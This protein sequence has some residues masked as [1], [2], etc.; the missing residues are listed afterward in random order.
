MNLK[1][2]VV[3]V[4]GAGKG[5][6]YSTVETL[7]KHGA[8]VYALIKSKKDSK[9]FK[10]F[11][12]K[13]IKIYFGD[14]KNIKNINNIM[15]ESL[16]RKNPIN[17]LVNNAGIRLRKKFI[18]IS[19]KDL[20]D[21]IETNFYSVF[22]LS[23]FFCK[24]LIKYKRPGSIINIA[25]IVGQTGFKELSAYASSKAAVVGLT[26]SL[27]A[28]MADKQIRVNCISPGFTKT[29]FFKKFKKKKNLYNWTLSRVPLKR[30]GDPKEISEAIAFLASDNSS[31][32]NGENINVDGGWV[33]A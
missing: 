23:Q 20:N 18:D 6:G 11:N 22:Y 21:V 29:S 30:W 7:L 26:K 3:L 13:K 33:N 4:T 12:N 24:F 14:V 32:V 1:N 19:K 8:F 28:E 9:Y 31:Y 10:K 17:C 25:S 27:A 15:A 16:K 2:K 5:I